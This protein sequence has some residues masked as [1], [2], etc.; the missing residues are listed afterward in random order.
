MKR[1]F[2]SLWPLNRQDHWCLSDVEPTPMLSSSYSFYLPYQ[3]GFDRIDHSFHFSSKIFSSFG[4][5]YTILSW[6]PST[7]VAATSLSLLLIPCLFPDTKLETWSLDLF[8]STTAL[9]PLVITSNHMAINMIPQFILPV[10][11]LSQ[12]SRHIYSLAT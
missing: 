11:T 9:S 1:S 4:P 3:S 2:T 12:K 5:C 7:S 6:F 10:R 8:S